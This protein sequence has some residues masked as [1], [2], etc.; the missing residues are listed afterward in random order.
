ME[1]II[2]IVLFV[3]VV[4][5]VIQ[6][7]ELKGLRAG[8][9]STYDELI[10]IKKL[11]EARQHEAPSYIE[12]VENVQEALT[13]EEEPETV[14]DP[15]IVLEDTPVV[16]PQY[17]FEPEEPHAVDPEFIV[18]AAPEE[19]EPLLV[20][21]EYTPTL[22]WFDRFRR[23]NP[24]LEKFIGENL[25]NKIGIIILV[26]G[27]SY[28]VK[29]AIDKD[30]I[31]E[32]GRVG[33]GILCG[34]L[35]LGVAHRLRL[36]YKA[37]S[38]VLVAGAITVFYFT[39]AIAFHDYH[40]FSQTTAFMIMVF[41]TAF[42]IMVSVLY[43]RQEL[44]V[45]SLIG[46]F[47]VPFIVSTGAGN[48]HVLLIYIL[49][50][51]AGILTISFFKRWFI[52]NF[53]AF[54]ATAGIYITW[55][56]LVE[57][58][59]PEVLQ[60]ALMYGLAFYL[61][62]TLAFTLNN[63][64][65]KN[66][67]TNYEIGALLSNTAIFYFAGQYIVRLVLPQY[68]GLF[69][70]ALALYN[71]LFAI[72]IYKKYKFDKNIIYFMIGLALTFATLT[73]PSQF[74]GK[75]ITLFWACEAV[76]LFWLSKQSKLKGFVIA[77]FILQV[78]TFIS[79]LLD[80]QGYIY[81]G[82]SAS[83][84]FLNPIFLTG[85]FVIAS[86]VISYRMFKTHNY[87]IWIYGV[88]FNHVSFRKLYLNTAL[89]LGYVLPLL[90]IRYQVSYYPFYSEASFFFLYLYHMI[91]TS[92]LLYFGCDRTAKN[93]RLGNAV[94]VFNILFYM[95]FAYRFPIKEIYSRILEEGT[96]FSWVMP[97]HYIS[98]V[99]LVYQA[100]FLIRNRA[101][102][103]RFTA[104]NPSY[105]PW[106][107]AFFVVYILSAEIN[108]AF[109]SFSTSYES[110][111]LIKGTVLRVV[112]P[113]LWGVIAF[114]FLLFGIRRNMKIA[115]IIALVFL[116]ITIF[117]LFVYDIS[118]AS[119]AGKIVAFILLGVLILIISFIYQKIKRL[120]VDNNEDDQ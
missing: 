70:L 105:L 49:I 111:L 12:E 106:C 44:A 65:R 89:V 26:L 19:E 67:F 35:I 47:A 60:H 98:L 16:E 117:K 56:K 22:T 94:V 2:T 78:L 113:V 6:R 34:S 71:L 84:A 75:Y 104:F 15:E 115:R 58:D 88:Y 99:A 55:L 68:I 114:V 120:I 76:L 23:D 108:I 20:E 95:A 14:I 118:N 39:I 86:L 31:N 37:F 46:G 92:A 116:G 102:N 72:V 57:V 66:K 8:L 79:L 4:L 59:Q 62:F 48:Y 91:Y 73:I 51:N 41:I 29:Y 110:L 63:M 107:I 101:R 74:S 28:F 69:P 82:P 43:N 61:M 18:A 53:V 109:L 30:W 3:L 40:L 33:V 10:R 5:A 80:L 17:V 52:V 77:G 25:I 112:F 96:L 54:L 36:Q 38:S 24:D 81:T 32:P 103:T 100:W 97:L 9:A 85:L 42:S 64:L 7:N 119:E 90:E 87:S 45:L 93:M 11:L 1:V 50:L 27:I 21:A 83:I 13:V